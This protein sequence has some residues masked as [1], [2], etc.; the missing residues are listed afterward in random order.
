MWRAAGVSVKTPSIVREF[1]FLASEKSIS[2]RK[3]I[4]TVQSWMR[5]V[6]NSNFCSTSNRRVV[7]IELMKTKMLDTAGFPVTSKDKT[8]ILFEDRL[9]N[10]I[11]PSP[12]NCWFLRCLVRCNRCIGVFPSEVSFTC[13]SRSLLNSRFASTKI[14]TLIQWSFNTFFTQ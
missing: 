5:I 14:R 11:L 12:S 7:P 9:D 1:K 4:T 10:Y 6:K 8:S 13:S 3:K 2:E